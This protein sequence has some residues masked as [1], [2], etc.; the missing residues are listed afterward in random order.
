MRNP[1]GSG[2]ISIVALRLGLHDELGTLV[3]GSQRTNFPLATERL[4]LSLAA[5]QAGITLEDARRRGAQER[6][7][8]ELAKR[9][10]Q[11]TAELALANEELKADLAERK[12]VENALRDSELSARLI[13]NTLPATAWSTL[14]NGYCDFL[15][16]RWLEYAGLTADEAVGWGWRA[17]IH[18][19][20]APALVEH[21][22][23]CLA[24]GTAVDAE[25]RMRRADGVYR[26]FLFRANPLRDE[27]GKIIKWYG[28]NIDIED[29]KRADEALRASELNLR[30]L[31]ET[32][33]EML[34]S[35]T[36]AGAVDYCNTRLLA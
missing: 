35:A 24:S 30:E 9:V 17:V 5:N 22:Q 3:A 33:P 29:R 28:T 19:D 10:A 4:L 34:W 32:I 21:W 27:D 20:D 18:P 16:Q 11:R 7:K 15:S 12:R 13:I 26:W 23:A 1:V 14:P 6:F 2:D 36:A 8:N 31:T 25:A